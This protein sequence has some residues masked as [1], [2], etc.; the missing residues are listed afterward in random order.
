M[1]VA[2]TNIVGLRYIKVVTKLLTLWHWL[3]ST[4]CFLV[5]SSLR[6]S[7]DC[8]IWWSQDFSSF[9]LCGVLSFFLL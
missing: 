3:L 6:L 9:V 4:H 7:G 2:S 8:S 5:L 1:L